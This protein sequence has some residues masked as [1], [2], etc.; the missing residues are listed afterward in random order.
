MAPSSS[1]A[2]GLR[3]YKCKQQGHRPRECPNLLCEV[4]K[5]KGHEAWHYTKPSAKTLYFDEL[6]AQATKK[7]LTPTLHDEDC[8]GELKGEVEPSLA[9]NN[10]MAPPIEDDLGGDG[11]EMV[12]HGNFPSTKEAHGDEKVE[13]TPICLIDELVRWHALALRIAACDQKS[14]GPSPRVSASR[15]SRLFRLYRVD[16]PRPR[17]VLAINTLSHARWDNHLHQP[18]RH[19]HPR[20]PQHAVTYEELPAELKK[21]HDEIKATLEADLIGSFQRTRP[22]ASDGRGSHHKVHSMG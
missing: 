2:Y 15:S 6:Q 10:T 11:V 17:W 5:A 13:P 16:G 8:Q 21:K 7:P 4:C 3:C 1:H 18:H 14:I 19:L 20:R 9:L 12:E 22:M